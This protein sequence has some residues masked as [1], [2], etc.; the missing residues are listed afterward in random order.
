VHIRPG[1]I[2]RVLQAGG[3]GRLGKTLGKS[4]QKNIDVAQRTA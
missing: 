4:E 2:F 1:A 3:K